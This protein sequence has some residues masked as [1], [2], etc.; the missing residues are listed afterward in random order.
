[1]TQREML[2]IIVSAMSESTHLR[3]SQKRFSARPASVAQARHFAVKGIDDDDLASR[4]ATIVSE[5]ATNAIRHAKSAFV[6]E[7]SSDD[8]RVR[9]A[10]TDISTDPP[11]QSIREKG[12]PTGRGLQIVEAL[13]DRWGFHPDGDGKVVW[14]EFDA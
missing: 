3:T 14:A 10:V 9:V 4:V 2:P 7:V 8:G 11:R 1:M 6:L 13:S 5:L 12:D